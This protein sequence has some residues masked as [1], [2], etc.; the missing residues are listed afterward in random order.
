[1]LAH[2][3]S[4]VTHRDLRVMSLAELMSRLTHGLS[5]AGQILVLLNLPLIVAGAAHVSWLA[6]LLLLGAPLASG[7]LQ[8]ALSRSREPISAPSPSRRIRP[9]SLRRSHASGARSAACSSC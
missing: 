9:A 8:L 7:L 6:I 2:E 3:V 5:F 4:H 1:V